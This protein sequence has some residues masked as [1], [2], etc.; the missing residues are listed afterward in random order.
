[1]GKVYIIGEAGVNHNGSFDKAK[2]LAYIAKEAGADAV[3][4]QTFI[5]EKLATRSAKKAMY[6]KI[7]ATKCDDQLS[8]LKNLELS[9]DQF[10]DLK[11][12]CEKIEIDFLSTAFDLDSVDFLRDLG[13]RVWKIPSGEITNYPYLK[14]IAQYNFPIIISTGMATMNEI[15]SAYDLIRN[16]NNNDMTIL[17]C[18]TAYPTQY[19]DVN[20]R[21]ML[22]IKKTFGEK[23]GYS[24]HTLGIEVP[25]AAVS[26]GATVIE[27]HFTI[28][29]N[30]EGPDH[31]AS[32]IPK[33]LKAM[34]SGIRNVELALGSAEKTLSDEEL[35][36]KSVARKSIVAAKK[37]KKG[38]IFS[39]S[40]LAVKR[41]G[42]GISPMRWEEII[43]KKSNRDYL[44][45]QLIVL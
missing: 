7:L 25:I 12:Y 20:L 21:T 4:F 19:E 16:Y 17:H 24:D 38:E 43:G 41:P 37:I 13:V 3:K 2:E 39:E 10:S 27:K 15:K 23:I 34:I 9:Y 8:M 45:D 35:I 30:L 11:A 6:Q 1:M 5:S 44:E 26:L 42:T 22:T 33:E 40:N 36:N 28:D 18:T 32:L 14:K 29:R 31:K